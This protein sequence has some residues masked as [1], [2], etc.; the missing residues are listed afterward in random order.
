M[1][2][3]L[4]EIS[5]FKGL[6][7]EEIDKFIK[8]TRAKIKFYGK[9]TRVIEAF[10]P[11]SNIGVLLEGTAQIISSDRFGNESVG[12]GLGQGSM[13]GVTSAILGEVAAA[14]SIELITE[15]SVLWIPYNAL[16][17]S[18]SKLGKIHGTVM[19]N[20]LETFSRRN[21]LMMQKI[22]LLSQKTIREKIIVYLMQGEK[23]QSTDKVKVPGRVQF[24]KE[25]ECNRSALTREISQMQSD[26]LIDFG[27]NWIRLNKDKI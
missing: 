27:K 13:L 6:T 24:A 16:L 10:V 5:F 25:L 14:D 17:I 21:F 4:T 1:N 11:N 12:H 15:A 18:G 20:F 23:N 7:A 26:G 8:A 3:D 19:K 9:G 2:I 22:N